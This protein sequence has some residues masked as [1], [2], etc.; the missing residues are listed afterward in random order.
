MG[1]TNAGITNEVDFTASV[2]GRSISTGGAMQCTVLRYVV[3]AELH[4]TVRHHSHTSQYSLRNCYRLL[5][6]PEA[7][8]PSRAQEAYRV[9]LADLAKRQEE[10][11]QEGEEKD[12]GETKGR[13]A[14]QHR[15]YLS[16]EGVGS[17]PPSQRERT[18]RHVRADRASELALEY[19]RR[20]R[21]MRGH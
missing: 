11:E 21:G 19:R 7:P 2:Y 14:L 17:G 16:Y 15:H 20:L 8:P 5:Q 18:Y 4:V 12:E 10:E 9:V 13:K 3:W 6:L 1:G